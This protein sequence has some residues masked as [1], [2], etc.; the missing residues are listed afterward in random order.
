MF[1]DNQSVKNI[2]LSRLKAFV[3]DD[4]R[5]ATEYE[6]A[7]SK[8]P[9]FPTE[10]EQWEA[11]FEDW[12]IFDRKLDGLN[13]T[14][15][16]YFLDLHRDI[17]VAERRIYEL[18]KQNVFGIFEVKAVKIGKEFIA[19]DLATQ[20]EYRVRERTATKQLRK[21]QCIFGRILPFE[22][23]YILSGSGHAYSEEAL[24]GIRLFYKK[25]R[26]RKQDMALNPRDIAEVFSRIGQ[27]DN[28]DRM[29]IETLEQE[30]R[31][32]LEEAGLSDTTFVEMIDDFKKSNG[33]SEVIEGVI[34]KAV[35]PSEEDGRCLINL[36]HVLWNKMPHESMGGLSP[37]ERRKS[38]IQGPQER[39]LLSEMMGFLHDMVK[40]DRYRDMKKLDAAI[41]KAQEKWL[42]AKTPE[43]DGKSPR[44]IILEERKRL[45]NDSTDILISVL[46]RPLRII[47]KTEKEAKELYEAALDLTKQDRYKEA[48]D[49]YRR[50]VEIC[51]QNHIVWGNMGAVN[52]M[53]GNKK[54]ALKCLYRALALKPDYKIAKGNL[55]L[56][57]HARIKDLQKHGWISRD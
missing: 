36:V 46:A 20:K 6:Q 53:M 16:Q 50:Y 47:T 15:L 4:K 32:K 54:E 52:I 1:T 24:Y 33:P 49:K 55:R 12:F 39:A 11:M 2:Y 13:K 3:H 10:Y 29:D 57:E 48:L 51:D 14:P 28:P 41:A 30:I 5:L 7:G 19:R 35:F 40:P 31:A 17:P 42:D 9:R 43:L 25:M 8:F 21:G 27:K 37:E 44:E 23:H 38:V 56:L 22:D 45:G 26:D 18:F 34:K